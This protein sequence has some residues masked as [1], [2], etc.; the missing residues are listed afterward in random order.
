VAQPAVVGHAL[1][2]GWGDGRIYALDARTGRRG[3]CPRVQRAP[4]LFQDSNSE[5]DGVR[6][7]SQVSALESIVLA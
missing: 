4:A 3:G 6:R 1:Y 7:S 2:V 5:G